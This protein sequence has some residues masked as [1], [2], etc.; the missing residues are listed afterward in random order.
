MRVRARRRFGFAEERWAKSRDAPRGRKALVALWGNGEFAHRTRGEGK[1][2]S[3]RAQSKGWRHART[4]ILLIHWTHF[5]SHP[6]PG[7]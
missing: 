2:A 1:A 7:T 3:S 5:Q 4:N 6:D